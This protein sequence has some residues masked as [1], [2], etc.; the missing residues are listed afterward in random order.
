[1]IPESQWRWAGYPAHLC[2][3]YMCRWWMCTRIGNYVISSIG[4]YVPDREKNEMETIG[5][6]PKDFFETMVFEADDLEDPFS[7][8]GYELEQ[9]RYADA[10]EAR[11]GHMETCRHWADFDPTESCR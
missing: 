11:E 3:S 8:S 7:W 6:G 10:E 9:K 5:A 1:M 4:H 2:V